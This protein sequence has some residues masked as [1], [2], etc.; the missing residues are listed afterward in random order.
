VFDGFDY[1]ELYDLCEDPGEPNNLAQKSQ[2]RCTVE[3]LCRRIWQ[4]VYDHND[5]CVNPYIMMGFGPV[6]P[7]VAFE[8][9]NNADP[10]SI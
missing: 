2:Y 6:G 7:A 3:A 9:N 10:C 8:N 1:D 4:F 5:A